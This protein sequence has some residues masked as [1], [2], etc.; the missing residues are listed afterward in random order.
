[1]VLK[2]SRIYV[3]LT[4]LSVIILRFEFLKGLYILTKFETLSKTSLISTLI[5][6]NNLLEIYLTTNTQSHATLWNKNSKI[7][8]IDNTSDDLAK[9]LNLVQM[10]KAEIQSL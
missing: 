10:K 3:S 2:V 9:M 5:S 7:L 1:M 6:S 4:S 8:K